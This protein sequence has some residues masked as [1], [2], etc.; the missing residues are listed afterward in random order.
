[1]FIVFLLYGMLPM[2]LL[3]GIDSLFEANWSLRNGTHMESHYA[4]KRAYKMSKA[5][6][7]LLVAWYALL[8]Y[9]SLP[10]NPTLS[11]LVVNIFMAGFVGPF[12]LGV[13]VD[14]AMGWNLTGRNG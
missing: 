11:Y 7:V 10:S 6:A 14:E 12:E 5:G 13:I 8:Y 3:I 1:M 2:G 4:D 9:L